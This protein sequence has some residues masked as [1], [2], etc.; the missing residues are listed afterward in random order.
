MSALAEK[1]RFKEDAMRY[2]IS[3]EE[4]EKYSKDFDEQIKLMGQY[5]EVDSNLT[6]ILN[7]LKI[8]DDNSSWMKMDFLNKVQGNMIIIQ[9]QII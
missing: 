9:I 1:E 4:R 5:G 6:K 7:V 3:N 8:K 2:K